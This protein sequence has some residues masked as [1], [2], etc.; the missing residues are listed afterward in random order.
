MLDILGGALALKITTTCVIYFSKM[1]ETGAGRSSS[2]DHTTLTINDGLIIPRSI[3]ASHDAGGGGSSEA[4]MELEI[5][6][7]YDGTNNPLIFGTGSLPAGNGVAVEKVT[8]GP[9]KIGSTMYHLQS[10]NFDFGIKEAV[11]G[12]SG[13]LY[14]EFVGVESQS[15][16]VSGKSLNLAMQSPFGDGALAAVI[17]FF[18]KITRGAGRTA[19]ATEEHIS[20]T[21]AECFLLHGE[22]AASQGGEATF[23]FTIH[24]NY[25]GTNA[26]AVIDTTAAIA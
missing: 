12:Q 13:G 4:E 7:E 24:A 8:L 9:V 14:P 21:M 25:D 15:P 3:S 20:I 1:T 16:A 23:D 26:I 11:K 6:A 17:L 10:S 18:R 5:I 19:D 2:S 22:V